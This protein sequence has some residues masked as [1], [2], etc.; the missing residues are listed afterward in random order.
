M[1]EF[2][3][4]KICRNAERALKR[5]KEYR[6]NVEFNL[7]DNYEIEFILRKKDKTI[8]DGIVA[9]A[10][11]CDSMISFC[12]YGGTDSRHYLYF[13]YEEDLLEALEDGA[14][15]VHIRYEC[16][17][18]IWDA[19]DRDD[20]WGIECEKGLQAYLKYCKQHGITK[21]KLKDEVSYTGKD[22]MRLYESKNLTDI[23]SKQIG[24]VK[25]HQR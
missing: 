10:L 9:Y 21:D 18:D 12:P 16:H 17:A 23:K 24:T 19:I 14:E 6:E 15:I 13:T 2:S 20:N 11:Y 3:K 4:E 8:E 7:D 1:V 22:A 25:P 5:T